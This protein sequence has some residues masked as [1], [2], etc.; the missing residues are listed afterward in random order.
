[1]KKIFFFIILVLLSCFI[2][3][4]SQEHKSSI[5]LNLPKYSRTVFAMDTQIKL[6]IYTNQSESIFNLAENRLHELDNLL[7]VTNPTSE[8]YA[9]NHRT[10]NTIK[11][12]PDT[13]N[14]LTTA[15]AISS[16]T[17][18]A[19][20]I[21]IYPLLKLWGFTTNHYQVPNEKS[22]QTTLPLV[23]YQQIQLAKNQLTLPPQTEIDLGAIAKGYSGDE[24]INLLKQQGVKSALINIG[25]NVQTL[26]T[27]P[28]SSSWQIGLKSPL[29]D[30]FIGTLKLNNCAVVTSGLYERF[31][32]DEQGNKYG[33]ILNPQ[34]GKPV[35]NDLL[36]VSIIGSQGII[37]D[38]LSTALFVM[39]KD[40]AI[41]Y[42][43]QHQDFQ[44]ILITKSNELYITAPLLDQFTL[45]PNYTDIV[46]MVVKA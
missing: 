1:M 37:C 24:I 13:T 40:K 12:N 26:G 28:D 20:D 35:D 18:G 10:H 16:Q 29:K 46:F 15:L 38:A 17:N 25:G 23:N 3:Y 41:A 6:I 2:W 9:I 21:T 36:S 27:K 34:T 30:D 7:S 14:I 42:W 39:G 19:F 4:F 44:M 22:I 32:I 31:F 45:N 43:Q 33:H 11:L 5:S 8:I